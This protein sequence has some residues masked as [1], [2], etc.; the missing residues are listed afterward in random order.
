MS[1]AKILVSLSVV[2]L[3]GCAGGPRGEVGGGFDLSLTHPAPYA[4]YLQV[5]P[6]SPYASLPDMAQM[7][8]PAFSKYLRA[9][10]GCVRDTS[11]PTEALGGRAVPAAYMVPVV[12]P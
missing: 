3:S 2:V 9:R 10:T 5:A 12:C 4:T 7:T 8:S 11:R 1:F 6:G